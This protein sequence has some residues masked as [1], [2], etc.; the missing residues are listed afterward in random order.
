M[1]QMTGLNDDQYNQKVQGHKELFGENVVFKFRYEGSMERKP[2]FELTYL[3]PDYHQKSHD[4]DQAE[5]DELSANKLSRN[6]FM[7]EDGKYIYHIGIID[8]LQS[9]NWNKKGEN[10]LKTQISD[11]KYISAVE[12]IWYCERFFEFMR[13]EVIVNQNHPDLQKIQ[14]KLE[15]A[16]QIIKDKRRD[17]FEQ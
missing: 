12:P 14:I 17:V 8:Y 10:F 3:D 15:D 4:L 7:S 2:D 5:Y 1:K 13:K 16:E 11:G 6:S 9:Y